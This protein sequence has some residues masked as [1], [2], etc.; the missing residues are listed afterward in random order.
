MAKLVRACVLVVALAQTVLAQGTPATPP[1]TPQQAAIDQLIKDADAAGRAADFAAMQRIADDV[2]SQSRAINDVVRLAQGISA[3]ARSH[4]G[5]QQYRLCA[6][7]LREAGDFI[8]TISSRQVQFTIASNFG[9]C[10]IANGEFDAGLVWQQRAADIAR[11]IGNNGL[12]SQI[13][14]NISMMYS[15]LGET[16]LAREWADRGV[17]KAVEAKDT[18]R[19]AFA[20]SAIAFSLFAD[21]E[22]AIPYL[23]QSLDMF[24][25]VGA[26]PAV[27]AQ[28]NVTLGTLGLAEIAAGHYEAGAQHAREYIERDRAAGT[29]NLGAIANSYRGMGV[30]ALKLG[31]LDEAVD[32]LQQSRA[33]WARTTGDSSIFMDDALLTEVSMAH[34]LR[35]RGREAEAI[36]L[37]QGVLDAFDRLRVGRSASAVS[38]EAGTFSVRT[39]YSTMIDILVASG[40]AADAF[41]LSERFRARIFLD[42]LDEQRSGVARSLTDEQRARESKLNTSAAA[43]QVRLLSPTLSTV[44]REKTLGELRTIDLDFEAIRREARLADPR[45]S[46]I[47]FPTLL[48]SRQVQASLPTN[49]AVITFVTGQDASF[50]V[51]MTNNSISAAALPKEATIKTAVSK[52]TALL[53]TRPTIGVN[54]IPAIR[55]EASQLSTMLLGPVASALAGRTKLIVIPD[56][57]LSALP[58]EALMAPAAT[59]RAATSPEWMGDRF[60]V[61]YAPSMSALAAL[62]TSTPRQPS[63]L[64]ALGDPLVSAP[65]ASTRDS[66]VPFTSLPYTRVEVQQI[67]RLFGAASRTVLGADATSDAITNAKLETYRYIHLAA[68]AFVNSNRP[69]RSGI[70]LAPSSKASTAGILQAD[71][72]MALRLNADLVTLSA[73]STAVGRT[74]SNE[75]V[76]S[77]ARSFLVAGS[78]SVAASLWNVNDEATATLMVK[79]YEGLKAGLPRDEA[80]S[81]AR[82]SLVRGTNARLKDPYYWAPFILIGATR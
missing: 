12:E 17:S 11:A 29:N 79:F 54:R 65:P 8:D 55:T 42:T 9:N 4:Y 63:S 64:F 22:A 30:A 38:V 43:L 49:T 58:I 59:R 69:G 44:D 45:N 57:P 76:L 18:V 68:H 72:V 33:T 51:A 53:S 5:R 21:P 78:H 15:T 74:V 20:L 80:L 61:S 10:L 7:T 13:S 16:G 6:D 1:P 36:A 62:N 26:N 39:A 24:D 40:R 47:R 50:V 41:D 81:A 46:A 3:R 37:L 67:A 73:C 82:R 23:Q 25:Q 28:G 77:L 48:S 66:T 32:H 60:V 70:V 35:A 27:R 14:A 75:G 34:V 31:R 52:F 2:I 56:G 71:D 19:H